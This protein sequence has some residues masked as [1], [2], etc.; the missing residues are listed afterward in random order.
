PHQQI[1]QRPGPGGV[2]E[3]NR[4]PQLE[5]LQR[6]GTWL[7]GYGRAETLR[8]RARSQR[9]AEGSDML[10]TAH[11]RLDRIGCVD[12]FEVRR[13]DDAAL[14]RGFAGRLDGLEGKPE[15]DLDRAGA[16]TEV[17]VDG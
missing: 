4:R 7:R 12:Q 1:D 17:L 6:A 9:G 14:L 2:I 3:I 8:R 10:D 15:V 16:A 5:P 13:D 11:T